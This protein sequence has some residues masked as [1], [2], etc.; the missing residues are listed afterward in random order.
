MVVTNVFIPRG[1]AFALETLKRLV[2]GVEGIVVIKDDFCGPFGRRMALLVHDRWAVFS[3][4]QKQNHLDL[5]PYGCDGYLSAYISFCPRVAH[6]Y[7]T[8]VQRGARHARKVVEKY[9]I[10]LF[11]YIVEL[12]GGFDAGMHGMLELYN[13]ASRWR[14]K[15]YYSLTDPE[16]DRLRGFL[17]ELSVL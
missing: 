14:R 6:E 16:M 1:A 5:V 13:L 17:Q 12:A 4:G 15:P 3:G 2:K 9:D 8:A 10:P 11:D 7:W